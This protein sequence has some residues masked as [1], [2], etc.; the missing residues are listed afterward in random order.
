MIVVLKAPRVAD[1]TGSFKVMVC[2]F[3]VLF[4]GNNPYDVL[5]VV[6]S[7]VSSTINSEIVLLSGSSLSQS[8]VTTKSSPDHPAETFVTADGV[9]KSG[10]R[11]LP[12]R[13]I[14]GGIYV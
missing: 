9:I 14:D 5:L 11:Y 6:P 8:N 2:A 7:A 13:L 4:T 1:I 12:G 3:C 10:S